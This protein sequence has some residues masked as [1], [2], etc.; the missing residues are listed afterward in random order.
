VKQSDGQSWEAAV[1]RLRSQLEH[2]QL[3]EACFYDDPLLD[4]AKR[5]HMSSEW[6]AVSALIGKASG[7]ALDLGAGRGIASYALA[8]EGWDVTALEPDPSAVVGAGAIRALAQDAGMRIHVV[9][10]WGESLPFADASF[11]LVHCRQVLH[12][13]RD[14]GLLCSEISRVLAPGG[15]VLATREHVITKRDDLDAFLD[16]HP[17]HRHYGG[18]N[19]Y[20]RSDYE[21]A[22]TAAGLRLTHVLNPMESDINL[23]PDSVEAV[24]SRWS[25]RLKLPFG[26]RVP[27]FVLSWVGERSHV[28]GRLYTFAATKLGGHK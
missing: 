7:A 13:A 18:E 19:A 24:R 27:K 17:L 21:N 22:L 14:L 9:E 12:H 28:P 8:V 10:S 6:S 15:V 20:L 26:S 2:R 4:A 3:V 11:K 1:L 5:Y 25:R 16:S 23:Y